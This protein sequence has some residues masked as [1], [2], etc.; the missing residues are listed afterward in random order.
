M[1][2]LAMTLLFMPLISGAAEGFGGML[3]IL[4]TQKSV[5]YIGQISYGHVSR[6]GPADS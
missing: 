2:K 6:P 1:M 5:L 3:G 4:L